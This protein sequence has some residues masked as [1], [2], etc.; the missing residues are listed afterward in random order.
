MSSPAPGLLTEPSDVS[1]AD[2]A[3]ASSAH[4]R[5]NIPLNLEN[6]RH[7]PPNIQASLLWFHQHCLDQK[8]SL[9]DAAT[10]LNTSTTTVFRC[11]KGTYAGS[12]SNFVAAIESYRRV[13]ATREGLPTQPGQHISNRPTKMIWAALDYAM[14]CN[15]M[16]LIV[17]ESGQG[18][19]TSG[20]I[21]KTANNHGR[22]VWVE[23]PTIGGSR[24]L[25]Q[26]I[27]RSVGASTNASISILFDSVLRAF[28]PHRI[29]LV[30][31]VHRLLPSDKRANPVHLE[32]IRQIHDQTG[33]AVGLFATARFKDR[34]VSSTYQF[35]QFLG[36]SRI[37]HLPPD[38]T[39]DDF[40][41]LVEQ[42]LTA[43]PPIANAARSLVE[44]LGHLRVLKAILLD[45]ARLAKV[46]QTPL[47]ERHFFTALATAYPAGLPHR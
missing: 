26:A 7:L 8:I 40:L 45:A 9:K 44:Q 2:Q 20:Q 30:D 25:L 28:N 18:K 3:T 42:F 15:G 35:E 5:V 21:W 6:W 36:R 12:Y 4:A 33:C 23:C 24:G 1:L 46:D 13:V 38:W 39:D 11:L 10:C 14:A 17:G 32:I 16:A 27:C 22:S 29:L 34:L 43:T 19:T 41:P 31:E 47:A 37:V